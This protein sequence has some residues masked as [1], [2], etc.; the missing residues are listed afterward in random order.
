MN[1]RSPPR[2]FG[3]SAANFH[4]A[5]KD[6]YDEFCWQNLRCHRCHL[7]NRPRRYPRI[8]VRD[9]NVVALGLPD[10]QLKELAS[11]AN[12]RLLVLEADVS[13]SDQ[14]NTAFAD[15][16]AR[17]GPL[18]GVLNAAGILKV[19]PIGETT[20]ELWQRMIQ[21]NLREPST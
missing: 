7:G 14:V 3:G 16:Q 2:K 20:D 21:V 12:D 13:K 5:V 18:N 8:A 10:D 19:V 1:R 6:C 17:F 15:A 9:A 11:E 4:A